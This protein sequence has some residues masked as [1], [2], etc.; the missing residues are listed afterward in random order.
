MID[1]QKAK[2]IFL[3]YVKGYDIN[4]GR[5]KLKMIH[6][7]NVAKNCKEIAN[8]LKLNEEQIKLAYLIGLFHDIGKNI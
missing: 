7:L 5:I 6:I 8:N 4:N 3:D 1:I 2:D